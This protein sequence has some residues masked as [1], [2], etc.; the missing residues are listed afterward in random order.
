MDHRR[1]W[2]LLLPLLAA[3]LWPSTA[4]A[5]CAAPVGYAA[6]VD[7]NAVVVRPVNFTGRG[8]PDPDGLLRQALPGG[9]V[10]RVADLCLA[11]EPPAGGGGVPYLDECVPAGRYR[12]GFA[13][14][15]AC[16]PNACST[17]WFVEVEVAAP[18]D[19][20][21]QRSAGDE[22]PTPA[23]GAPWGARQELCGHQ[24]FFGCGTAPAGTGAVLLLDGAVAALGLA[25]LRRRPARRG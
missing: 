10:V 3:A 8:C 22:G 24:G 18:L 7:G 11:S 6:S 1:R 15:Y 17:A 4:R 19:P 14:P 9:E 12:Y 21:C 20:G 2:A 13:A 5:N 16:E 25:L 23:A